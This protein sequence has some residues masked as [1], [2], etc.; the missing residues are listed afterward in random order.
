MVHCCVYN[1]LPFFRTLSQRNP[2]HAFPSYSNKW[3]RGW[4]ADNLRMKN[5]K[6]LGVQAF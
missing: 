2:V 4:E 6:N 3:M 1:N 5:Q